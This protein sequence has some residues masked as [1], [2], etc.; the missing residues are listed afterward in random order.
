MHFSNNNTSADNGMNEEVEQLKAKVAA[1]EELLEVYQQSAIEK[2][3]KLEQALEKVQEH[4]QQLESSERALYILKSMLDSMGDGVLVADENGKFL[5]F[6]PAAEKLLGIG[7]TDISP[8]KWAER[9]SLYLPDKS[10]P[11]PTNKLPLVRAIQGDAVDAAEIFVRRPQSPEGMWVSVNARPLKDENGVP[12]GGV[13]VFRDIT[14]RKQSEEA[15]R[16]QSQQL[17]Q[18]FQ[19]LRRTQSQ[20]IQTEKMSSLGQLVAGVAHEINNPVNFIYGNLIHVGNYIQDLFDA[21]EFYQQ[22][23]P[24]IDPEVQDMLEQ[25]EFDFLV[26]DLPKTLSSM[27][28]GV[29]RIREIVLSLRNFSRLDEAEVKDSDIHA[30]IDSTL[31]ILNHRIK[32]EVAVIRNYGNLPLVKC[33]PAQL[34]QVF[35]NIIN[36]AIDSLQELEAHSKE[37]V[38]STETIDFNPKMPDCASVRVRIADNGPG[39]PSEAQ[40]KLFDPFFTTKPVGKGTG[41]G[42]SICYQIIEK[43]SG[44]IEVISEVGKGTEFIIYLPVAIPGVTE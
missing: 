41:L 21:I 5:L 26:E 9:Y 29:D 7:I 40:S 11:Y 38:I 35:M 33:Y 14:N 15:L 12:Q 27:K 18:A 32:Q 43:H 28:I 42:L 22:R 3:E 34:N 37:I 30:G 25:I 16:Q 24:N 17:E 31:L 20:L 36:N 23:C 19:S 8:D 4:A 6:N 39:I 10:T 2:S 13:A 1:L 44:K